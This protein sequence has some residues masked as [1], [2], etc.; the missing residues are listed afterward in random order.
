VSEF[1][2][3]V[4]T[5]K[6]AGIPFKGVQG[7]HDSSSYARLFGQ[8][9]MIHA[10]DAGQSRIILLNTEESYSTNTQFLENQL[11]NTKQ[12]W[13]IVA[14]HNPLYSSPSNHP[15]EKELAGRLQPL[16]D[17]YGVDLVIYGH[18]HNYERIKLPDKSTVFI[19]AGI[20]GES[21]YNIKG[22]RSNGGV[23]FQDDNDYGFVK[24]TINSNTLSGQFISHGGKILD[25]FSMVK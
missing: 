2:P 10:F 17:Q 22:D 12:P 13:K 5:L 14:M 25:S 1:E 4:D 11:K 6:A 15:E 9:S 19:Q 16:F 23:E 21:H 24:L 20:G 8:P 7:N 3:V 18:N